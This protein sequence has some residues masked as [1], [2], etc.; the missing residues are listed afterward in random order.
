MDINTYIYNRNNDSD[1]K[2]HSDKEEKV[3][4][5]TLKNYLEPWSASVQNN[6][7]NWGVNAFFENSNN[8]V[9]DMTGK[10]V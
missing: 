7:T 10:C 6:S 2:C 8:C 1:D 4:A 9:L 5:M 3:N